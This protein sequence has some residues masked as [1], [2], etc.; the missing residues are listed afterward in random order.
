M[1]AVT[2]N[3][4]TVNR[5]RHPGVC[6]S[7]SPTGLHRS[8]KDRMTS[9]SASDYGNSSRQTQRDDLRLP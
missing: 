2:E 6:D 3:D 1:A 5:R 9:D 8:W 4:L 7:D